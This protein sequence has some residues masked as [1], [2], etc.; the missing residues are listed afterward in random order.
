MTNLSLTSIVLLP[1]NKICVF[2]LSCALTFIAACSNTGGKKYFPLAN[3]AKWEYI[4]HTS[5]VNSNQIKFPVTARVDGETLINGK[6][7]FKYILTSDFSSV[8]EISKTRE[9]VR[10]YRIANDGIYY[11]S[12]NDPNGPELLEMPLP[13]PIG[14]RWLSGNTEVRAERV[15]TLQ[16]GDRQYRD[17]LKVTFRPQGG[18]HILENYLAPDVGSIKSVDMNISEPKSTLELTLE[19]YE[20]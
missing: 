19:K 2:A 6:L 13:I 9:H 3:G 11:R 17:C 12:G 4:G 1:P 20:P 10:Y 8:P 14:T 15:G 5:S 16:I 7:Y 18:S